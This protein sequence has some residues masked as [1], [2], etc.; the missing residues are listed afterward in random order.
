M[1]SVMHSSIVSVEEAAVPAWSKQL[2]AKG[3]AAAACHAKLSITA[4][5]A[6]FV[7]L[8]CAVQAQKRP[9]MFTAIEG[10]PLSAKFLGT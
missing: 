3:R 9:A 10:R 4:A 2:S 6:R 8:F 5:P 7:H 1:D